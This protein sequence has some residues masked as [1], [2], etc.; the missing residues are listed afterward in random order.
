MHTLVNTI[1]REAILPAT[2]K[3][4]RATKILARSIFR[5][6]KESGLSHDQIISVASEL[7]GMVTEQLKEDSEVTQGNA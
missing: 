5:E 7:I 1:Q 3:D 2:H 4:P 6:M